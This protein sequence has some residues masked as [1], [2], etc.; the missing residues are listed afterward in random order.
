[1]KIHVEDARKLDDAFRTRMDYLLKI[2]E[3][4]RRKYGYTSGTKNSKR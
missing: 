1:M 3:E 4:K 2:V